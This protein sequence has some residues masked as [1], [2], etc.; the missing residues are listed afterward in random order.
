[1]ANDIVLDVFEGE[2][3]LGERGETFHPIG[4][5]ELFGCD[6]LCHQAPPILLRPQCGRPSNPVRSGIANEL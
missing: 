3:A 5:G 1:M 6:V 4:D 2:V